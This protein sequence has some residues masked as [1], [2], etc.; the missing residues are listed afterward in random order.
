MGL[1]RYLKLRW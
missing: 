1:K